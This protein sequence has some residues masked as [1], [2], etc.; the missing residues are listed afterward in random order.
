MLSRSPLL[1]ASSFVM[2]NDDAIVIDSNERMAA[3]IKQIV[4]SLEQVEQE[5]FGDSFSEGI[6][7]AQVAALLSEDNSGGMVQPAGEQTYDGPSPEEL[8]SQA[9]Y[10]I[11]EMKERAE[12]EIAENRSRAMRE[13]T[14]EGHRQGYDQG[15]QEG[16]RQAALE[17]DAR[18]RELDERARILQEEYERR[19][20]E[21][22]PTLIDTLTDIYA[23]IFEVDMSS[24]RNVIMHLIENTLHRVDGCDNY[25]V[26]VSK[27]DYPYVSMQKQSV[28]EKCVTSSAKLEVVED[29]TLTANECLIETDSGIYDCSVGTELKELKKQL[30]LLSYQDGK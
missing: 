15:Y 12:A 29:V 4:H 11:Q 13:A 25:L 18:K 24:Y 10:E 17:S 16:L 9:E 22:E 28:L 19:L 30:M 7:A 3:K 5:G 2:Q 8:I 26:R 21:V 27:E 20:S 1:K 6:E 14:E 23:H